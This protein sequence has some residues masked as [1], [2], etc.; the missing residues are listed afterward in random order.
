MNRELSQDS[1]SMVAQSTA[2]PSETSTQARGAWRPPSITIIDIR[3]TMAANGIY[4]DGGTGSS[5]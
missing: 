4:V 3:R 5:F 1:N 2:T